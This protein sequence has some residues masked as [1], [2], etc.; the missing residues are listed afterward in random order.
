MRKVKKLEKTDTTITVEEVKQAIKDAP[1]K[2]SS[3]PDDIT[4][5][6]L[7]HQ[8]ENAL[9]LLAKLFTN[10]VNKN[11]IPQIWK[12]ANIVPIPKPDKDLN[13]GKSYRPISLISNIAKILERIILKRIQP[14]LPNKEYQHGYKRKHSTTT[15]LQHLTNTIAQGF[16]KKRP[17]KRTILVAIDMSRAF[18]VIDH[19]KLIEKL[20]TL[21][22][23]PGLYIKFLAN[24]IQGRKAFTTYN[25][26][27]SK[28]RC[29]HGGVPQGG[30]LSPA[31]FNLFMADMPEPDP[32]KGTGLVVYADDVTL[33]ST[34]E[35]ISIAESNAQ[36]Y[37][38]RIIAWMEANNLIL[39]DKTQASLF[40]PDPAE[41]SRALNLNIKGN[42][43]ETTHHPKILGLTFDKRLNFN[44]HVK[45]IEGRAKSS[46]KL[47]KAISGTTWGQQKETL[48]T[49]Y[50]QYTRPILEYACAAWSPVASNT[51]L[52]RL[53]RVQNA[54]LRCAT[55]HTR[56]TNLNHV[57][58]E[59]KVLPLASHMRLI[60]SQYR[61]SARDPDH[62]LHRQASA[63]SPER[64]M[65][66]TAFHGSHVLMAHGCARDGEEAKERERNKK[67]IHTA[68]V[69]EHLETIPQHP[70]LNAHAP[71]IHRSDQELSRAARRTLA[72]LRAGKCPLLQEYLQDIGAAEDPRC[73]LCGQDGHNT[74][75]LFN[76]PSIATDLTPEDL[77]RRP[78]PAASLPSW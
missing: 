49:T 67:A 48:V 10:V 42:P 19:Q 21:T 38:D 63:P 66:A 58:Q 14:H 30:V 20:M 3:G 76:C 32:E 15:A 31:L 54:A 7:K 41:Y 29:F 23:M 72:Q 55:G 53:Q 35:K 57:H 47:V 78:L 22:D 50:K 59:T 64:R 44:E 16:N 52:Q 77:W 2:K 71:E 5:L 11:I 62:P 73:P 1:K 26:T 24:Y 8:G 69:Q 36:D 4:V 6:H 12:L 13:V 27:K 45:V 61:E 37:L 70:L 9:N 46:L 18:D 43:L 17:P 60:T 51:N 56:D 40:T 39:A 68:I 75:H 65:K 25:K 28:Q 33:S 74:V 34:H